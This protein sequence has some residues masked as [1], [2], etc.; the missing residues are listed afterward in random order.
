MAEP[1]GTSRAPSGPP[2]PPAAP[3]RRLLRYSAAWAAGAGP[4]LAVVT[5]LWIYPNDFAGVGEIALGAFA[6]MFPIAVRELRVERRTEFVYFLLGVGVAFAVGSILT[7]AANGLTDEPF[8]TPRF[9][10]MILNH[11]DPYVVPLVFQYQQFGRTFSFH[12]TYFYL[13]LLPFLQIPGVPYPWFA[14]G[15]WALMVWVARRRFDTAVMLAQPYMV[16]LAANGYNDLPVLLLLTVAFVGWEGRRQKWA[17][18]LALGCKQ[19]ANAF[20]LLY[21]AVRRDWRNFAITGAVSAAFLL[22]FL[23]WSGPGVLCGALF[24]GRLPACASGAAPVFQLNYSAW[25]VWAVALFYVPLVAALRR[26]AERPGVVRLLRRARLGFDDLLRLPAFL[27]VGISGVFVNLCVFTLL[28]LR[29]PPGAQAVFLASAGAFVVAMGW[30]FLWNRAWAFAGRGGR[31]TAYHLGLYGVIQAGALG[32]NEALLAVGVGVGLSGL[33]AQIVG[34]VAGSLLGYAANLKWNF[35]A[36]APS[37]PPA[38]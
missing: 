16:L 10:T 19:F 29:L 23:L 27:V 5:A 30:N 33:D 25:L 2:L 34:I 38:T 35:R 21:Y 11:Q 32:V 8:T 9:A 20:L 24:A 17:E 22:P 12:A 28:G 3:G 4:A 15:T 26:T 31:S 37:A 1:G 13:P 7:G 36:P 6:L 18:W 14:L